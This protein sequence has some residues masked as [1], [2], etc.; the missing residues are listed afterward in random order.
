VETDNG[1]QLSIPMPTR[2]E[3]KHTFK[4]SY[5]NGYDSND[6]LGPFFDA[7]AGEQFDFSD[8]EEEDTPVSTPV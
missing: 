8:E 3:A 2:Q 4:E 7:V 6:E 1:L 5:N